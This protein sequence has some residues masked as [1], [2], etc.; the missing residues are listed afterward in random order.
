MNK[1]AQFHNVLTEIR[2]A[3]GADATYREVLECAELVI[4]TLGEKSE[5]CDA[6]VNEEDLMELKPLY[7]IFEEDPWQIFFSESS[8]LCI[9]EFELYQIK[10]NYLTI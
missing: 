4:R 7:E 2:N 9:D 10:R 3:L 6:M 5:V 1:K 8:G